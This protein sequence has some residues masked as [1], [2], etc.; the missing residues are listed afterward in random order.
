VFHQSQTW[1]SCPKIYL[2]YHALECL[3]GELGSKHPPYRVHEKKPNG[4]CWRTVC[5]LF[6]VFSFN[7]YL[8]SCHST[9]SADSL[10][11]GVRRKQGGWLDDW[12]E[13]CKSTLAVVTEGGVSI[14]GAVWSQYSNNLCAF[15][16]YAAR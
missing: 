16:K 7:Y 15:V 12:N 5:Q 6:V 2:R 1:C 13:L 8:A 11:P 10:R 14:G 4:W 3:Q 9:Q